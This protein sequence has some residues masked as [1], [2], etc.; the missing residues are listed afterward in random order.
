MRIALVQLRS[1]KGEVAGNLA[2]IRGQVEAAVRD[3]VDVIA[4]PEMSI[5]GYIDPARRPEA[6]LGLGSPAVAEFAVMTAG[7]DITML[8]G[9]VEHNPAGKPF[10]TQ[11]VARGGQLAGV[12]RKVTVVDEEAEWFTAG[13]G[14]P[15]FAHDGV[16][17]GV[18]ICADIDNPEVFERAAGQGARIVFECAAPGLY[19]EQATRDWQAGF[20]WWRA[21]CVE[22]LAGYARENGIYIAVA[23]QAGRT[24]DEDFPGGGYLFGPDGTLLAATSD[25]SGG[26]LT[27]D[28]AV[29]Q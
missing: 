26:V 10:I 19:G 27:V 17:F 20:E 18:A 7:H 8:A 16:T 22:K 28:V 29:E 2:R 1:E 11:L 6:V 14:V 4:F 13:E 5:T 3:G 25:W 12:Y 21:E 23:T 24:V 9:I 15:V